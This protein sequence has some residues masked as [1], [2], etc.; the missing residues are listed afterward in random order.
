MADTP[1]LYATLDLERDA[2]PAAIKAAYRK[3]VRRTHPDG[4]RPAPLPAGLQIPPSGAYAGPINGL[5]R[6]RVP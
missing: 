4:A 2:S 3:A 1:D 5:P 6:L